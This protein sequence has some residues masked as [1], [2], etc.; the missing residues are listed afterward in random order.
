MFNKYVF[1]IKMNDNLD[2]LIGFFNTEG[3]MQELLLIKK[4]FGNLQR[5]LYTIKLLDL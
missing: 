4:S 5:K 2:I 3:I 1:K